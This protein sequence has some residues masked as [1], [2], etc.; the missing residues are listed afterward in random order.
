MVTAETAVTIPAV[1]LVLAVS[2]SGLSLGV[3][4]VRCQDAARVGVRELARGEP[5]GRGLGD[6]L[7][8]AGPGSAASASRDGRDVTVVVRVPAPGMLAPLGVD[9]PTCTA[10]A[11]VEESSP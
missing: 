8:A 10:T 2:L 9:G 6:A 7:R 4:A 1:V 3:D 5:Q 11:R